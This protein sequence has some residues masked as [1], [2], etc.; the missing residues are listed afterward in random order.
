MASWC[1]A[2]LKG[3]AYGRRQLT[4]SF[5][6]H[7]TLFHEN[8]SLRLFYNASGQNHRLPLFVR[9]LCRIRRILSM[10]ACSEHPS[11][12]C[13]DPFSLRFC[14]LQSVSEESLPARLAKS[15]VERSLRL[16]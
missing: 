15:R 11:S 4:A 14:I 16:S 3:Y 8:E 13:A 7:A 2:A 9:T 1:R 5:P 10:F 12:L 6:F